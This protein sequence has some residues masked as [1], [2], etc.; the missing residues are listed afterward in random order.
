M[1]ELGQELLLVHDGGHAP[2][3]DNPSFVHFFHSKELLFFFLFDLPNFSETSSPDYI[4]KLEL[5][6]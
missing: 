6:F 1:A 4:V 2:L 5:L 3:L